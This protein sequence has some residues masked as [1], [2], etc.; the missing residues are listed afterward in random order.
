VV[1]VLDEG[2]S[3]GVARRVGVAVPELFAH[4]TM[5]IA[6][7]APMTAEKEG[8]QRKLLRMQVVKLCEWA[9]EDSQRQRR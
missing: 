7:M 3:V 1:G 2:A 9:V 5:L 8:T 4:E 6:R